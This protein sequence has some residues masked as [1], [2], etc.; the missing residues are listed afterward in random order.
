M[1]PF[2]GRKEEL[3]AAKSL[4]EV[5]KTGSES[6]YCLEAGPGMGKSA[7]AQKIVE[8]AREDGFLVLNG[9]LLEGQE[10]PGLWRQRGG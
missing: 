3:A 4:L 8:M 2:V 10:L 9:S 6:V 5:A 1:S 7:L